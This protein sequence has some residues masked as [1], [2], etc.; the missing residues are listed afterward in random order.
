LPATRSTQD[1]KGAPDRNR[2]VQ[3]R[4][5]LTA[6]KRE[7]ISGLPRRATWSHIVRRVDAPKDRASRRATIAASMT[8]RNRRGRTLHSQPPGVAAEP[9]QVTM[10]ASRACCVHVYVDRSVAILRNGRR[11]DEH[12]PPV[13]VRPS[14]RM[15]PIAVHASGCRPRQRVLQ[16]VLR[17]EERR[18][19]ARIACQT[20]AKRRVAH[21]R[22]DPRSTLDLI[23]HYQDARRTTLRRYSLHILR[24]V[25]ATPLAVARYA[26]S[27]GSGDSY[28]ASG[29]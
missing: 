27:L 5:D 15:P 3:V 11:P 22:H 24:M 2:T 14:S 23:A 20:L 12:R 25:I 28:H 18:V 13:S 19:I 16:A 7:R 21:L 6:R 4:V 29:R 10:P 9:A 8:A 26:A 17:Y 1:R